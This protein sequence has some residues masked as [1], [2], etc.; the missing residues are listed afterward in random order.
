M[1]GVQSSSHQHVGQ[2]QRRSVSP[3]KQ[4]T[5]ILEA[6]RSPSQSPSPQLSTQS[7]LSELTED[8]VSW[9][10][11]RAVSASPDS[12]EPHARSTTFEFTAPN[13]SASA[14][15]VLQTGFFESAIVPESGSDSFQSAQSANETG[16]ESEVGSFK[17]ALES[18]PLKSAL[19]PT[20]EQRKSRPFMKKGTSESTVSEQ[21]SGG[22]L[23]SKPPKTVKFNESI[24]T[25]P[26]L[27]EEVDEEIEPQPH[28]KL[29]QAQTAVH[30][31]M[32]WMANVDER[33][34]RNAFPAQ[35]N[36]RYEV[37][38]QMRLANERYKLFGVNENGKVVLD[39]LSQASDQSSQARIKDLF[40]PIEKGLNKVQEPL[41][42][43]M[44]QCASKS[45]P[46]PGCVTSPIAYLQ[47][48]R[49]TLAELRQSLK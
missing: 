39:N 19:K 12:I 36:M 29:L 30:A 27:Q 31:W 24:L 10:P 5:L 43:I 15:P 28:D 21:T 38:K 41:D 9:V 34:L 33:A 2:E 44:R 42:R 26:L 20:L 22:A 7:S 13:R 32:N 37:C 1:L 49:E 17:T 35:L 46:L 11:N 18:E 4:G 6:Q 8:Y 40:G 23:S 16:S 45:M 14:P 3:P 47:F 48:Y 25:V